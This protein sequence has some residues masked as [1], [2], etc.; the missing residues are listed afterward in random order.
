MPDTA[1]LGAQTLTLNGQGVRKATLFKVKVYVAGL[2]LVEPSRDA[3]R[4][5]ASHQP[6]RLNLAFLRDVGASQIGDAWE[7]GFENNAGQRFDVLA[8]RIATLGSWM[9]AMKKGKTLAFTYRLSAGVE[10][11]V[12]ETTKGSIEGADF[13]SALL[14][15][16]LG[17]KPPNRELKAGLLGGGCT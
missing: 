16:F 4:I 3:A 5:L 8:D 11:M 2:Y 14:S 13:A 7:E 6:W 9:D 12:G 15:I 17:P 10:V 1:S